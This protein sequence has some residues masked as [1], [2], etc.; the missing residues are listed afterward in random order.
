MSL[1]ATSLALVSG[2]LTLSLPGLGHAQAPA[3]PQ[4][5]TPQ[6]YR[7]GLGDLMTMTVQPRHIKLGLAAQERTGAMRRTSCTSSRNRSKG[8][9]ASG[10]C[11]GRRILPS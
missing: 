8:S 3:T 7:P 9:S 11:T 5:A 10:R 1:K 2:V 6:A 4:G